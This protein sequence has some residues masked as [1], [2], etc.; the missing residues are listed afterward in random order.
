[1]FYRKCGCCFKNYNNCPTM[2][3]DKCD[4]EDERA[5]TLE[6]GQELA[7]SLNVDFMEAS[8]KQ[9][10]NVDELFHKIA[11]EIIKVQTG[12]FQPKQEEVNLYEKPKKGGCFLF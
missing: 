2:K 11:E 5:V 9:N 7:D 1:M 10:L 12:A 4:L 8:A 3:Y 6:Q